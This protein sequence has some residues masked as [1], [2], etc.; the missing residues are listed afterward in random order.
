MWKLILKVIG[1]L[2][3]L[4]AGGALGWRRG[5]VCAQRVR[6]LEEMCAFLGAVRRELHFRCGRTEEILA[7]AQK[8]MR[9]A[10][11]PLYFLNLDTGSGLQMELDRALQCTEQEIGEITLPSERATL[12]GALESLGACPAREEEQRLAHAEESLEQA[13]TQ[14]REE[15]AVQQKLYRTIGLSLGGAAALL[16]L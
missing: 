6:V 14:A 15:A 3:I 9:L 2:L 13:L 12:R 5:N 16:L 1:A 11:L 8:N 10:V 7:E 4:Y